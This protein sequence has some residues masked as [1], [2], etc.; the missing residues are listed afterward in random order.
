MEY[1][2][3]NYLIKSYNDLSGE[4][5]LK[6]FF[7]LVESTFGG[8]CFFLSFYFVHILNFNI[9]NAG[10]IMSIY[11]VGTTIGA[12]T[13]GK[14]ADI[15]SPEK[16]AKYSLFVQSMAF[17]AIIF[18]K[19]MLALSTT[20]FLLGISA[21]GFITA[22][23]TSVMN[24]VKS[25]ERLKL[26]SVNIFYA[27]SNFG[28]G[29][30]AAIVMM[31][32][33]K[34]FHEIFV[35]AALSLLASSIFY[36]QHN[37]LKPVCSLNQSNPQ[38]KQS[39]KDKLTLY[40]VLTCLFMV[41]IIISQRSTTYTIYLHQLFPHLGLAGAAAIFALNPLLIVFF[42]AP[43]V[44]Q[45]HNLNKILMTGV[46]ALLMGTGSIILA[47]A[48]YFYLA[49]LSCVIYTAGEMIFFSMAQV[50]CYNK[51]PDKKKGFGLGLFRSTYAASIIVGP[52]IGS[53]MYQHMG[54]QSIWYLSGI[55]GIVSLLLC[56]YVNSA[57]T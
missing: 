30:A 13:S 14:L 57:K 33:K 2:K 45:L 43:L 4:Y 5:W 35:L 15:L 7:N 34:Y 28:I 16:I 3:P 52:T 9:V 53:Q 42:Q 40:S 23:N 27:S 11:G 39:R 18:S 25:D 46:G 55:L 47:F 19:S 38:T 20:M 36:R 24:L 29:L 26:K 10:I 31:A 41:G 54:G 17:M 51:S 37:K 56:T 48:N 12:I 21:Y 6:A 50:S 1:S 49:I 44:N 8:I 32:G 22:N